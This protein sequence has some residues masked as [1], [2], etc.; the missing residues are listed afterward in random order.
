MLRAG[1]ILKIQAGSMKVKGLHHVQT[2]LGQSLPQPWKYFI[3]RA[4]SGED[5]GG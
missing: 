1:T 2:R 3:V 5:R 4:I